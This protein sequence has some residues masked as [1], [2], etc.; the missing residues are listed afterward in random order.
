[1]TNERYNF[2]IVEERWQAHWEKNKIFETDVSTDKKKYYVLEMF[3]YPSGKIH[4]GHVRNYSLGDVVARYKRAKGYNVM[5]PMGW[6]AF[7]MPAENAA[8]QNNSHPKE[9]TYKNIELM[10][11]QLKSIGLAIDWSKEFA[12]CDVEYYHAQQIIFLKMFEAGLVFR[13][14]SKVNWDPVDQ[15]VLANE[16]VVD[17]CGWRSGAK[18]ELKELTQWF[19]KISDFSEELLKGLDE[20]NSWPEKVRLMQQNWIGKSQ[21]LEIRWQLTSDSIEKL[22]NKISEVNI[23]TTRAETIFGASFLALSFEHPL[24]KQLATEN[25]ALRDFIEQYRPNAT[26][27]AVLETAEKHGFDLGLFVCH[28]LD[29]T[30]KIPLY[31]TNFVLMDYGTGAIFGCPAHDQRD[32]EFARKYDLPVTVVVESDQIDSIVT[33]KAYQGDGYMIN[34]DFLNGLTVDQAKEEVSCKLEQQKLGD[35]P[36]A[37]RKTQYR[38]RDW[39]ISRQR[40][41]GCPIPMVHC[42]S[43]GVVPVNI[44]DL[45]VVLPDNVSFDKVGNPLDR[46]ESWLKTTCP[47]CG[48]EARRESDTMDTFVDSSWYYARFTSVGSKD[49]IVKENA[50]KWLPVDQYIGGIE[51]AI[52]H[53][54]YARFFMRVLKQIGYVDHN[55][56]FENLFTQ[57]MVVHETYRNADGW[58]SP[59]E[60]KIIEEN[61]VRTATLLSDNSKVDIGSVEKMSKSKKNVINPDDIIA[62]YGADTMRWFVLSDSP[63]E[64]DIVWSEKGIEGAFR[65]VQRLWR[66]L[67][68]VA[69]YLKGVEPKSHKNGEAGK[70]SQLAHKKL[71]QVT[72]EI[73]KLAFNCAIAQL[74]DYLNQFSSFSKNIKDFNIEQ[75]QSVRQ[76]YEFFVMMISPFMPHLAEEAFSLLDNGKT[77]VQQEWPN[78]DEQLVV[79]NNVILPIQ[80]NGKKRGEISVKID[81][82]AKLLEQQIL[83]LDFV[84]NYIKDKNIKKIVI[85]PNRIVN[86]VVT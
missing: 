17:G 47:K 43:C 24:V 2:K 33:D 60:I 72:E 50:S 61:G 51:H 52:L 37:Q 18:V 8:M 1:M 10:R 84:V 28:P 81:M 30:R 80:I 46:C 56:P 79:D 22:N 76:A 13:S 7:G 29:P 49:A 83:A 12:T 59:D 3:P 65:Y 57:G 36:Q 75:L 53:L 42:A 41:W 21:G 48:G 26:S 34:S 85:V 45:P 86:I 11:K 19:L 16:Q 74:Y 39:G 25:N 78:Y 55:E 67:S 71:K 6:D 38:L 31:A 73:E 63:P 54:L 32:L 58:I 40:Y 62:A 23:Y 77:V 5:H 14:T 68:E 9:W 44:T 66:V 35:K 69:P 64:R 82:D 70:I 4:I 15:T 20:I 27:A